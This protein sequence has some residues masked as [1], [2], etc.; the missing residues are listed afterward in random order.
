[1]TKV[2]TSSNLELGP[3]KFIRSSFIENSKYQNQLSDPN[4]EI[5]GLIASPTGRNYSAKL[6]YG[7]K[8][9]RNTHLITEIGY[10]NINEQVVCFCH[11]CDKNSNPTTLVIL[12]SIN[13]GIGIRYQIV[14]FKKISFSFEAIGNY[15]LLVNE[16][17]I[18][19]FGYSI[20]PLVQYELN[21]KLE[22]NIKY[23][24]EQSFKEYEKKERYIELAIN[25]N[26]NKKAS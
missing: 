4:T 15:S 21:E 17:D 13:A 12:N 25:Y 7:K 22:V 2:V 20:H 11:V 10:A 8:V 3:S 14:E 23:G 9:F 18:K 1:M 6:R 5:E 19:Y 24:Y 16:S 26:I